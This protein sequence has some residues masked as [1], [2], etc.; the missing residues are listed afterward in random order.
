MSASTSSRDPD[1][2]ALGNP[3]T[4]AAELA[5]IAATRP[6]LHPAI[7]AHPHCYPALH[8]WIDQYQATTTGSP[9]PAAGNQAP[10]AGLAPANTPAP[11]TGP[12]TSL[13]PA[14]NPASAADPATAGTTTPQGDQAQTT[15]YPAPTTDTSTPTTTSNQTPGTTHPQG[16][17][18]RTINRAL[19]L[20]AGGAAL[21][22]LSALGTWSLSHYLS[23]EPQDPTEEEPQ[24]K[25]GTFSMSALSP[26]FARGATRTWSIDSFRGMCTS[27]QG[28]YVFGLHGTLED[29]EPSSYRL[30]PIDGSG[31]GEPV[32]VA[33][34]HW[35]WDDFQHGHH[36]VHTSWW[37]SHPLLVD[38]IIDPRSGGVTPVPWD[39][40][41]HLFLGALD[42]DTALLLKVPPYQDGDGAEAEGPII[43]VNRQMQETWRTNEAYV[44]AFF[45][46]AR[47]DV[48][49]G[50]RSSRNSAGNYRITPHLVDITT[51]ATTATLT[52]L[53]EPSECGIILATDGVVVV[54]V[55]TT[56]GHTAQARA[57][58]WDGALQ[59]E[60]TGQYARI[61][62][63]GVPS[64]DV[65][66]RSLTSLSGATAVVAE[67]GVALVQNGD[68][69]FS[70]RGDTGG[71]GPS[72]SLG[73]DNTFSEGRYK[74]DFTV[75]ADGSA[76]VCWAGRGSSVNLVDASTGRPVQDIPS[77]VLFS[78]LRLSWAV[79]GR[80]Y[81]SSLPDVQA[82]PLGDPGHLLVMEEKGTTF[83]TTCYVPA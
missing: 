22:T 55:T 6:D 60:Q 57:F 37:G 39:T 64:V 29:T 17:S 80:Q 7:A 30:Y 68:G 14:T 5:R 58:G 75:L 66:Q 2:E 79:D 83:C 4:P 78:R 40:A 72:L 31:V 59:W 44:S 65:V 70:R 16:P 62:F 54:T 27:P 28:D 8:Q 1:A 11:T 61:V 56:P 10:A 67:N 21:A 47:P 35:D 53:V 36:S 42:N 15:P 51:G 41:S 82:S 24:T 49:I 38:K 25:H 3:R 81:A 12:A 20:L 52:P 19:P 13:A 48:L 63:D 69:T 43:A 34:S 76:A 77:V 50:Y 45:D 26:N 73:D 33:A 9:A 74:I 18:R 46:P 71:A 32:E 23:E